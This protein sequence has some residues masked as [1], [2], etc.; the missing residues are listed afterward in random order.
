M[1]LKTIVKAVGVLALT[2]AMLLSGC[3]SKKETAVMPDYIN[4]DIITT[5]DTGLAPDVEA[6]ISDADYAKFQEITITS[7]DIIE[8]E[9]YLN[10]MAKK[11]QETPE[12]VILFENNMREAAEKRNSAINF[13]SKDNVNDLAQTVLRE[14]LA[15]TEEQLTFERPCESII[16]D[17]NTVEA[18]VPMSV[19]GV[20]LSNDIKL[21]F[22]D[23]YKSIT[24]TKLS[25]GGIMVIGQ[26]NI[27]IMEQVE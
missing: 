23:D 25:V 24:V 7:E 27:E 3:S 22:S 9:V 5:F 14:N 6:I 12:D 26:S 1:K 17:E 2:T 13:V 20:E 18:V 4:H 10:E 19:E 15:F 8:A 16:F 21:S 11:Y